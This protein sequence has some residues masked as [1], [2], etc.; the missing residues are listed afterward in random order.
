MIYGRDT[1]VD[2]PVADLYDTGMMGAYINAVK[3][4]YERGIKE[5]EDF[6]SKYGDFISPFAKDVDT[7]NKLTMEPVERTYD[8]LVQH[9][10]DP[11]RSQEGRSLLAS[12]MRKVPRNTLSMLRQSAAAG[13]EYLSN[14]SK[15]QAQ[16]VYNPEFEKFLLGDKSF[17]DWDTIQSG[18]WDRTSP[19]EYKGLRTLTD[20]WFKNRTPKF[21]ADLTKKR[22]DGFQY[23]TYDENDMRKSVGEQIQAFL[24]NDYGK[25]YYNRALQ[26]AQSTR[27]PGESDA[28]VQKR[29]MDI[30]TNDIVDINRDYLVEKRE[31]DPYAMANLKYRQEVGL[32]AMKRRWAKE[33]AAT[34]NNSLPSWTD[35]VARDIAYN[36]GKRTVNKLLQAIRQH[37][38][39]WKSK[40]N[41]SKM[42]WYSDYYNNVASG[43]AGWQM[44]KY[45]NYM[46]SDTAKKVLKSYDGYIEKQRGYDSNQQGLTDW[47]NLNGIELN[48]VNKQKA[49]DF[50]TNT[51]ADVNGVNVGS[52]M[53]DG[54]NNLARVRTG[55]LR[56]KG[57][58]KYS[59]SSDFNRYLKNN[60]VIGYARKESVK[61]TKTPRRNGGS[62]YNFLYYVDIPKADFDKWASSYKTR[63]NRSS[64]PTVKSIGGSLYTIPGKISTDKDQSF[65]RIPVI[66]TADEGT[67]TS[68]ENADMYKQYLGT[69]SKDGNFTNDVYGQMFNM[70]N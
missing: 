3:G 65:V 63:Y 20:P 16:G 43:K 62:S 24:G 56:G 70:T 39:Y 9:G 60:G 10:I 57:L 49:L 54:Q 61:V 64:S 67:V 45:G 5:R 1:A 30:L 11:L 36:K 32:A 66:R 68:W 41:K 13:Q 51:S 18:M 69:S 2:Y 48:G 46:F 6:V 8:M 59:A 33:D 38:E 52:V 28:S 12:V 44:D 31:V 22:R 21:N 53:F 40:G 50:I 29:A 42:K 58:T 19:T 55:E 4:E 27:Q 47:W 7:W 17:E 15:L 34:Q 14:R 37:Y 25:Y 35:T 26:V 23:Y